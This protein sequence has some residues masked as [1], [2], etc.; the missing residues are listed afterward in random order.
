K[1]SQAVIHGEAIQRAASTGVSCSENASAP[2][3]VSSSGS[4]NRYSAAQKRPPST[5][6]STARHGT[7]ARIATSITAGNRASPGPKQNVATTP[8]AVLAAIHGQG[9][10]LARQTHSAANTTLKVSR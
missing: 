9:L 3:T 1:P 6:S 2:R 8:H 4:T 10:L 7:P 5:G